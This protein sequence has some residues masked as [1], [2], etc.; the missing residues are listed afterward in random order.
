M[1]IP[2]YG[3]RPLYYPIGKV[4]MFGDVHNEADKLEQVLEQIE[5]LLTPD[6]HIV[7]CGDLVD[8][9]PQAALTIEMLVA[10]AKKYP[11]Q[12]FFVR[13]NHDWM[14]ANYL[15]TGSH[16]WMSYLIV[17]L[18]DLQLKWNLPDILPL[19]ITQALV[20]H[21]FV[22]ITKRTI[23]YYETEN[24]VVTHAP[25]D[26]TTV[27]IYGGTDYEEDYN[28]RINDPNFRYLLE[29]I[30]EDIMW[31]FTEESFTV[32]WVKKFRVCGHQPGHHKHPRIFKDR[33]FID[34][35]CGK[36]NRPLTCMA[37]P[38]KKYWQSKS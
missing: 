28:D 16:N 10:L 14:L 18:S 11:E 6:D 8:R 22:E 35:G 17:T 30:G 3:Q 5:P 33:A 38:G 34:T 12:V 19:T 27:Q 26:P 31:Q 7:F 24:M 4:Y 25:L 36:G 21:E 32:P 13:G 23:P 9:G 15:T 2:K 37:Y 1:S 29:R 20:A